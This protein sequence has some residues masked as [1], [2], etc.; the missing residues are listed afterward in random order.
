VELVQGQLKWPVMRRIAWRRLVR[1]A[2]AAV[3]LGAL[4]GAAWV[5]WKVV[6]ALL[7]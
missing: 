4:A 1:I 7:Y 5:A 3:V 6:P 2:M